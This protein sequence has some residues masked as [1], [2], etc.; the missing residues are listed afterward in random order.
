MRPVRPVLRPFSLEVAWPAEVMGPVESCEL[1]RLA[2]SWAAVD[3][4]RAP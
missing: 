4:L 2:A 1:A 3:I